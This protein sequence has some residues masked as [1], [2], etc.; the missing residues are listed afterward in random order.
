MIE[1]AQPVFDYRDEIV[2]S[3]TEFVNHLMD[4]YKKQR[5]QLAGL[6]EGI[7]YPSGLYFCVR[8]DLDR[9]TQRRT[10]KLVW[11]WGFHGLNTRA[12]INLRKRKAPI[13]NHIKSTG[14]EGAFVKSDLRSCL[15][16]FAPWEVDLAYKYEVDRLRPLRKNL[17][18]HN[19]LL[20]AIKLAPYC[21]EVG[22]DFVD[23]DGGP[24]AA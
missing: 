10:Y 24:T 8:D 16:K 23:F 13:T 15:K 18:A 21:T 11:R 2:L 14:R 4:M 12:A 20:K 22:L 3:I 5:E 17:R 9:A 7:Y 1:I 6:E 19:D